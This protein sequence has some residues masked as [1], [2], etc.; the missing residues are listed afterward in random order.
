MENRISFNELVDLNKGNMD[1]YNEY[2]TYLKSIFRT[3]SRKIEKVNVFKNKESI[4]LE[5]EYN[6]EGKIFYLD[7]VKSYNSNYIRVNGSRNKE[8]ETIIESMCHYIFEDLKQFCD[9][10]QFM[11]KTVI[12]DKIDDNNKYVISILP[13]IITF[14][15]KNNEKLVNI[16]YDRINSK[17]DMN[18]IN[19]QKLINHSNTYNINEAE[20][21]DREHIKSLLNYKIVDINKVPAYLQNNNNKTL[22]KVKK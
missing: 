11:Q 18:K 21:I 3:M 10:N 4:I 2:M 6:E 16:S 12:E 9:N 22:S 14:A 5:I 13:N 15:Y 8:M 7:I 17:L 19:T 1:K 20:N